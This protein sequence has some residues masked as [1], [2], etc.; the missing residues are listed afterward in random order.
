M[1]GPLTE[2]AWHSRLSMSLAP[3]ETTLRLS[4]CSIPS[5]AS[6]SQK[7]EFTGH[8]VSAGRNCRAWFRTSARNRSNSFSGA[9][10]RERYLLACALRSDCCVPT[11]CS[12]LALFA[13]ISFKKPETPRFP[14]MKQRVTTLGGV[15]VTLLG[16]LCAVQGFEGSRLHYGMDSP[17]YT[18]HSQTMQAC[19]T[20]R[21]DTI[22]YCNTS[23]DE[24]SAPEH[25]PVWSHTQNHTQSRDESAQYSR[26]LPSRAWSK[27]DACHHEHGTLP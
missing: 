26:R 22:K 2:K 11:V 9:T 19:H 25:D 7:G 16:R 21:N 13:C 23:M 4:I 20:H 24:G 18:F 5:R 10:G 27:Y 1:P 3:L 6:T 12:S 17:R 8:L 14:L 15:D